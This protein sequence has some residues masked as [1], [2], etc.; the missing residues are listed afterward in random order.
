[1]AVSILVVNSRDSMARLNSSDYECRAREELEHCKRGRKNRRDLPRGLAIQT[2]L[3]DF[4][5]KLRPAS[6]VVGARRHLDLRLTM[7]H[8]FKD[9]NRSK[10]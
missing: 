3:L 8:W 7:T 9:S 10:T 4:V 6:V 5:E 1:M 2:E